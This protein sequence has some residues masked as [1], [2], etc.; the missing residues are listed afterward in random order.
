MEDVLEKLKKLEINIA[1][2]RIDIFKA[3]YKSFVKNFYLF[4]Q[5]ADELESK[6]NEITLKFDAIVSI[7][8]WLGNKQ[9]HAV[10]ITRGES[11]THKIWSLFA[12]YHINQVNIL[13]SLYL[14]FR[15]WG[16]TFKVVRLT[17]FD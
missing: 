12:I 2:K 14:E 9:M 7:C 5:E 1:D 15:T 16:I 4:L 13:V 11:L 17:V 8:E 10:E 6:S 3:K